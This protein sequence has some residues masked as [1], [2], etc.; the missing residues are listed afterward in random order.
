MER[1]YDAKDYMVMIDFPQGK[2]F[3]EDLTD[4]EKLERV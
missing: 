3:D 1:K 4:K 2:D